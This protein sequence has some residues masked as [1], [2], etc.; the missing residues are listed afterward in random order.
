MKSRNWIVLIILFGFLF[1][2]TSISMITRQ[3]KALLWGYL[4]LIQLTSAW[5]IIILLLVRKQL[6]N[7]GI[8]NNYLLAS[9]SAVLLSLGFPPF[10]LTFFLFIGFVPLLIALSNLK[11]V[12]RWHRFL[13][14]YHT[15]ILWNIFSTYWV[16]NTAYAA[17]IF[18]NSVNALLM[19]L[20]ILAYQYIQGKLGERV[21]LVAFVGTWI[22]FEFLHMH[23]DLYWPWLTLGNGLSKIHWAVQWYEYTGV[24][25]G[26]VWILMVNYL[27][28]QVYCHRIW[29]PKGILLAAILI[30]PIAFSLVLYAGQH[31][32]E[33]E[34]EVVSV[35]PNFEPHYEK[36]QM[37]QDAVINRILKLAEPLISSETDYLVLPETTFSRV[38]MD[39]L[40]E[41]LVVEGFAG[42]QSK[43]PDLKII[44]GLGAYRFLTD[45]IEIT[46]PTTRKFD[47]QGQSIY[48]EQ[49]N[50]AVQIGHGQVQEYYKALFV[51]GAEFFPFRRV[52]FFLKP[53]VDQLGGSLNGYRVRTHFANFESDQATIAPPICYESIF[54]E[55][56]NQF[57]LRGAQAI[58]IMTNDGWWDHTAGHAQHA[59]YAKLRAI[60]T[61][62]SITRAANM[63]TTCF[64]NPRGDI[65]QPTSYGEAQAIKSTMSLNEQITFYVKWGD[66][67]GRISL[68]IAGLLLIRSFVVS[69]TAKE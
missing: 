25:G 45:S 53:I 12:S 31:L 26:S 14:L 27:V 24:F 33:G 15:F 39:R 28:F 7:K 29:K 56:I 13:L 47:R 52:L 23:W 34:I 46:L 62:R 40:E 19:T 6:F 9:V 63:G 51:P 49:Y 16:A 17:G 35:Q 57:V 41:S 55:F 37:P 50:A 59:Q 32:D 21:S 58:F 4:P 5:M 10:P 2:F 18:A 68:F 61:R 1:A 65:F 66:V 43:F 11:E 36:F 60:E 42:L 64:I 38:D 22:A 30:L 44:T 20:P 48:V 54:G 8:L 69:L 3:Q 67:L